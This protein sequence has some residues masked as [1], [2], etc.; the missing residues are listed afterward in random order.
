MSLRSRPETLHAFNS[1]PTAAGTA[2]IVT[3][4]AGQRIGVYRII[5]TMGAVTTPPALVQF[6]GSVSGALSQQFQLGAEG[7]ITLDTPQDQDPWWVTAVGENL[8]LVV[9]GGNF[10]YDVYYLQGP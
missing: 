9:S 2:T 7:A 5:V 3:G 6:S 4:V 1:T 10:S 8:Q